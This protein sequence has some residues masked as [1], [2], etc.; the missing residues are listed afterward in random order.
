[1]NHPTSGLLTFILSVFASC[2][3]AEEHH[4]LVLAA[5]PQA[6]ILQLALFG[7]FAFIVAR[8]GDEL[9]RNLELQLDTLPHKQFLKASIV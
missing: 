6:Q 2:S 3:I 7:W 8:E 5:L 1:M 9:D 4:I